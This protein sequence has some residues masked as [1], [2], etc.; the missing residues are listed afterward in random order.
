MQSFLTQWLKINCKYFKI[1]L[2][3]MLGAF[4]KLSILANLSKLINDCKKSKTNFLWEKR[5]IM[6][7]K[8]S[9]FSE[10]VQ[11]RALDDRRFTTLNAS[12]WSFGYQVFRAHIGK[13]I[14]LNFLMLIS[15]GYLIYLLIGLYGGIQLDLMSAPFSANLG[16]GYMPYTNLAGVES[17]AILARTLSF[18]YWLPIAG[19][20]LGFGF[21]GGMYVMRNLLYLEEVKAV[22]DFFLG[23]KKNW[24]VII[25]TVLYTVI[26]GVCIGGISYSNFFI[27]INGGSWIHIFAKVVC[28]IAIVLFT[29]M[30]L[31]GSV[32]MTTYKVKFLGLI[33]NSF[34]VSVILIPIHAFMLFI[35]LIPV[36][37]CFLGQIFMTIGLVFM[38]AFGLSFFLLVWTDYSHWIYEKFLSGAEINEPKKAPKTQEEKE[39]DKLNKEQLK[40]Q[41]KVSSKIQLAVKPLQEDDPDVRSLPS[42]FTIDDIEAVENSKKAMQADSDGYAENLKKE[43]SEL[44]KTEP[45]EKVETNNKKYSKKK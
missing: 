37:I 21:S 44:E 36:L 10:L 2:L 15:A 28:I 24:Q 13:I 18:C 3:Y 5:D 8:K 38:V 4:V 33:K 14:I 16:F 6:A 26:L 20:L 29:L 30:F 22:K 39:Q 23:I 34:L 25:L 43:N 11:K 9:L 17:S 35:A 27:S 19:I 45:E 32:M 1:S 7:K 12:R 31:N 40:A 42:I 41:E